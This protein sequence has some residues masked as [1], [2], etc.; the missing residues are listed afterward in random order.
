MVGT[1]NPGMVMLS[2]VVAVLASYTA[3]YL[4]ARTTARGGG[5]AAAWLM[6]GAIAMGIGIWS[7]HFVGMLA[8]RLPIPVGYDLALTCYSMLAAILTSALALWLTSR[9]NLPLL[10]LGLGALL[11]GLGIALMHYMGMDAL[12]M[13]PAIRYDPLLFGLSIAI[14]IGASGAALWIAFRLRHAGQRSSLRLIAA[15]IMGVAIVGMHYTGMAAARFAPGSVC[16]A[17]AETH[18]PLSWLT[19]VVV[20]VTLVLLSRSGCATLGNAPACA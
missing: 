19:A 20:L 4:A 17:V 15:S 8:F 5:I 12:R 6:G 2:L 14:A 13:V 16:G 1:Y 11:M 7:M 9:A 10:R 3:L 18:L